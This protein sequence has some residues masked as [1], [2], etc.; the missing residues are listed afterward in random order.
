[1][2]IRTVAETVSTNADMRTL[3]RDGVG[4]GTWL[5]AERQSGGRGRLGRDWESPAGNLYC[6]TIVRI[7][8]GDPPP[9]T[10]ALVTAVAVHQAI[11]ALVPGRTQIKWPNDIMAGPAKL[12]GM[13][14]ER[15]GDAIIIG[16]GVNVMAHP[17]IADRPTTS[18]WALGAV[19]GSAGTLIDSIALVFADTLHV[20]RTYG[21]DPIRVRWLAAAH[22]PGTPLRVSL[23]DGEVLDGRFDDLSSGGELILRLDNGA[24]RAIHAGDV[25][26]V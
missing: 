13:L 3:A 26:L 15:T 5:R 25:F 20:W 17:Q 6:S 18:L 21:L 7:R 8:P 19:E 12:C 11:D 1:M 24:T 14:L 23:P 16:I 2:D 9:P 4:E 22:R 10:L